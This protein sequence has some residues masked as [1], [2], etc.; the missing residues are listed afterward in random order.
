[1]SNGKDICA[2]WRAYLPALNTLED[3]GHCGAGSVRKSRL[4]KTYA[5]FVMLW[6]QGMS[7]QSRPGS[8]NDL[9]GRYYAYMREN[10]SEKH[11]LIAR[12][13][14]WER[15][16]LSCCLFSVTSA[17]SSASNFWRMSCIGWS[18]SVQ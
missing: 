15:S 13:A 8:M 11:T 12:A 9:I 18:E 4:E 5:L 17:G 10:D 16:T 7:F 1:M 3:E 6:N 14:P 2:G